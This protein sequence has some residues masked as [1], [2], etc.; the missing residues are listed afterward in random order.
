[1]VTRLAILHS[2]SGINPPRLF[3]DITR[4]FRFSVKSPNELGIVLV[5]LF[6]R[7]S[8]FLAAVKRPKEDGIEPTKLLAFKA[9]CCRLVDK[10]PTEEGI[11]PLKLFVFK[12][13]EARFVKL[14]IDEGIEPNMLLLLNCSKD[15]ASRFPIVDGIVPTRPL[16]AKLT[17]IILKLLHVT[18]VQVDVPAPEQMGGEGF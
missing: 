2:E 10:R 3:N 13:N 15:T 6:F 4:V 11:V 18:P 12:N 1:M 7:T 14:D 8:I 5:R 16:A 9:N 17:L